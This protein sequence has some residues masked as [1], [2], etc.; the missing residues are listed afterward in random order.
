MRDPSAISSLLDDSEYQP[1]NELK[2]RDFDFNEKTAPIFAPL[3]A[4]IGT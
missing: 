3:L 1:A 4:G 2:D